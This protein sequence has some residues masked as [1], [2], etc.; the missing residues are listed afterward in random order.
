MSALVFMFK[1]PLF[2]FF[3]LKTSIL[4]EKHLNISQNPKKRTGKGY[5]EISKE[6]NCGLF[7]IWSGNGSILNIELEKD[8]KLPFKYIFDVCID[9]IMPYG[10][11]INDVYGL[12]DSCWN[13]SVKEI[14]EYL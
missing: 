2:D 3:N 8:I 11:G 13:G 6:T 5:I 12:I 4:K 9:N 14:K 1:M 7:D 10:Y